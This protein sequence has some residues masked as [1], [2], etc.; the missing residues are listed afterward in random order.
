MT[1][2]CADSL[3]EAVGD[4]SRSAHASIRGYI[5]QIVW[6]ARQ[7]LKLNPGEVL[8]VEGQEDLDRH[9]IDKA[10][11]VI[12]EFTQAKDLKDD[13]NIRDPEVSRVAFNFLLAYRRCWEARQ[14][15]RFI[16]LTTAGQRD[17]RKGSELI[18]EIDVLATWKS[19][20]GLAE[21][22]R[23][24]HVAQLATA[25]RALAPK[26]NEAEDEASSAN[27][28]VAEVA[29]ALAWLAANDLWS[30][31]LGKVEWAFDAPSLDGQWSALETDLAARPSEVSPKDLADA[32]F[33]QVAFAA[34]RPD[35]KE[36]ELTCE[37]LDKEVR[38]RRQE[39]QAQAERYNLIRL[40]ELREDFERICGTSRARMHHIQRETAGV[41]IARATELARLEEGLNRH[42]TVLLGESG[43]GK[44]ALARIYCEQVMSGRGLVLW[45]DAETLQRSAD[46]VALSDAFRLRAPLLE[47][48]AKHEG[49]RL[50]VLDAIDQVYSH[51][52]L[53]MIGALLEG[54]RYGTSP[55]KV[56]VICQPREWPRVEDALESVKVDTTSWVRLP[57][58][59][60]TIEQL[61]PIWR[62]LPSADLLWANVRLR[63]LVNSNLKMLDLLV[64]ASAGGEAGGLVGETS[65]ASLIWTRLICDGPNRRERGQLAGQLAEVLADRIR[66]SIPASRLRGPLDQLE[67]ARI[68]IV[69]SEDRVRFGHDIFGD[70]VRLQRLIAHGD[71]LDAYL[72][73]DRLTS[74][75]WHRALRLYGLHL[76]DDKED[77]ALWR[78]AFRLLD[79]RS[80]VA[81]DL[82][83][84]AIALGFRAD[85]HLESLLPELLANKGAILIRLLERFLYSG[86]KPDPRHEAA[87]WTTARYPNWAY[88]GHLLPFLHR[89][90]AE[91]LSLAPMQVAEIARFCLDL[92][93]LGGRLR[94]E[95]GEIAL[96]LGQKLLNERVQ[97]QR[98]PFRIALAAV[99]VY[100]EEIVAF[101]LKA[102][103]RTTEQRVDRD[104]HQLMA[105]RFPEYDPEEPVPEP[106]P[107]G[108]RNAVNLAFRDAVMRDRA[109]VPLMAR[110]PDVAREVVL[111]CIIAHRPLG[112]RQ[113]QHDEEW[114]V[115]LAFAF[116]DLPASPFRGPFLHLLRA[117]FQQGLE[118]VARLIDFAVEGWRQ[119]RLE[120]G[121]REHYIYDPASTTTL[122]I[123]VDGAPRTLLGDDRVFGWSAGLGYP[124]PDDRLTSALMALEFYVY[125]LLDTHQPC[126]AEVKAILDRMASVPLLHVLMDIGRKE[127]ELFVG[128]L[129]DLL[130]I[131]ELYD[132]D[133]TIR[134][135]GRSH[136]LYNL[137][138][139]RKRL[140]RLRAGRKCLWKRG[141]GRR[142]TLRRP[143]QQATRDFN[144][145]AHR[146]VGLFPAAQT[147]FLNSDGVK[148]WL[149]PKTARWTEELRTLDVGRRQDVLQRLVLGFN[150]DN[151]RI[152]G[153]H[154][155]NVA[156]WQYETEKQKRESGAPRRQLREASHLAL[157][158]RQ[159][160]DEGTRLPTDQ[161]PRFLGELKRLEADL[162]WL[163]GPDVANLERL[164]I[165]QD[166]HFSALMGGVSVLICLHADWL[167]EEP[168][169]RA[170][171]E[172][173]LVEAIADPPPSR[174]SD[175]PENI[176]STVWDGFA[177]DAVVTL[178]ER[179]ST[180]PDMRTLV[181]AFLTVVYHHRAIQRLFEQC[182][183]SS[184][185]PHADLQR[186]RRLLFEW[187]YVLNRRD[188]LKRIADTQWHASEA[189][190]TDFA[191]Q[192]DAWA[193]DRLLAFVE[194]RMTAPAA[195]WD[196]MDNS[197]LLAGRDEQRPYWMGG[198]LDLRPI[199][200]AHVGAVEAFLEG[201]EAERQYVIEFVSSALQLCIQRTVFDHQGGGGPHFD[202]HWV[203]EKAAWIAGWMTDDEAPENLWQIVQAVPRPQM[204][205][206]GQT[207]N[208]PRSSSPHSSTST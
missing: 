95:A 165:L 136:L 145:S 175:S 125:D 184:R 126:E 130:G 152:V 102:A 89:H 66:I 138:P 143:W 10:G 52:T 180:N 45:L 87:G 120:T 108:P 205:G 198:P 67:Q 127:P 75:V 170:W 35:F 117:D 98:M 21:D 39:F 101:A 46:P 65:L 85:E 140:V 110:R 200:V 8:V 122:A 19:L 3:T 86:T 96:L 50:L 20:E 135:Q 14:P 185:I 154:V 174:W 104:R 73:E 173:V 82:L 195:K 168:E 36:R 97:D 114:N 137:R 192:G 83:L 70:W 26:K 207:K 118:A 109:L 29:E 25:L 146:T 156:L 199:L 188:F 131:P 161:L 57:L 11:R 24:A 53:T 123:E 107:D 68:C 124:L 106:P 76:S 167:D 186:L 183:R 187:A 91:V 12:V 178:W 58:N 5:F 147:P 148:T 40:S 78:L 28:R 18:L 59:P 193:Q 194:A 15:C 208:G 182:R 71:D 47:V 206:R 88:W 80:T 22:E 74:P 1:D 72:T 133:V 62:K 51:Q 94:K 77:L 90:R 63:N 69:D 177:A 142:R 93:E 181:W 34:T 139:S 190:L 31:F 116:P 179:D 196:E 112:Y 159:H 2:S 7:W 158:C 204:A 54:T 202:D 41:P 99:D 134:A 160:L 56:L 79:R 84:E 197:G 166:Q 115:D 113:E 92:T 151:F 203:I 44:S 6:T 33:R 169:H 13:V 37:A 172:E 64:R 23:R 100:E 61:A 30:D 48:I 163:V 103:E 17:Q 141:V 162:E 129:V 155:V 43:T 149:A 105:E 60:P 42:V 201:P 144:K 111:A 32:L 189:E 150:V 16:F 176:M 27:R 38:Q 49:E 128:P 81:A 157:Q 119:R 164:D 153:D 132:W 9:I 55:C 4:T 121:D 191:E 171:C